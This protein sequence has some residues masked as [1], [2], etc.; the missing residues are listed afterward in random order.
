VRVSVTPDHIEA[1]PGEPFAITVDV[2][3]TGAIIDAYRVKVLGL[4]P[5]WVDAQPRRLS[6]FPESGGVIVLLVTLPADYPAGRRR[7]QLSVQSR[8]DPADVVTLPVQLVVAARPTLTLLVDPE[9]ATVGGSAQFGVV[10]E[11]TGNVP[12]EVGLHAIDPEHALTS[13]FLPAIVDLPAGARATSTLEVAGKRPWFGSPKARMI[14]VTADARDAKAEVMA[15]VIQKAR[16]PRAVLAILGLMI[17]VGIWALILTTG[18]KQVVTSADEA[19]QE[20][21]EEAAAAEAQAAASG[22]PTGAITG[23]VVVQPSGAAVPGVTVEAFPSTTPDE[24]AGS[25]ATGDD[26]TFTLAGLPPADY[27]VRFAADGF[28]TT[29]F[30][31]ASSADAATTVTVEPGGSVDASPSLFTGSPATITGSVTGRDDP[32]GVTVTLT[33][34][35]VPDEEAAPAVPGAPAPTLPA[36]VTGPDGLVTLSPVPAPATYEVRFSQPGWTDA[37]VSATVAPGQLLA[38]EPVTMAGAAGT[39]SGTVSDDVGPLGGV[40][41]TVTDG[42]ETLETT[43]PTLGLDVGAFTIT[44]L[45]T[46]GSYTLTFAKEGYQSQTVTV[47]LDGGQS[48]TGINQI[49]VGATGG[50]SGRVSDADGPLGGV[51]VTVTNGDVTRTTTSLTSGDVGAWILTGLPVPGSYTATFTRA[52]YAS[53][54]AAVELVEPEVVGGIDVVLV[55]SSGGVEGTVTD[56]AGPLGGVSVTLSNGTDTFA[57]ASA[58]S[59][60]GAYRVDNLPAGSFTMRLERAGYRSQTVLVTITSGRITTTDPVMVGAGSISGTVGSCLGRPGGGA[61]VDVT[62]DGLSYGSTTADAQGT[63]ALGGLPV[64]GAYQLTFTLAGDAQPASF[65]VVS[66]SATTPDATGTSPCSTTSSTTEGSGG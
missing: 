23:V 41:V 52:G 54:T 15:S 33:L 20:A 18:V 25:A 6:L 60:P 31:A 9:I 21:A 49:M 63:F 66:L 43:T 44:D 57:T 11:N 34:A 35:T 10:M 1:T 39:I 29:W 32:S 2:F 17:A 48:L 55:S 24:S 59:P 14:T 61:R 5:E 42:T 51:L 50:T 64:P 26:G 65:L 37:V 58:D 40:V 53:Q 46:P 22:T 30:P 12:L 3:N 38:L 7:L 13:S 47:T 8:V 45:A 56:R 16:I 36:A 19:R 4:N 28:T 27:L 62:R